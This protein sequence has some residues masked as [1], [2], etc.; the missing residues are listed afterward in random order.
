MKDFTSKMKSVKFH[1][2]FFD[3]QT[4]DYKIEVIECQHDYHKVKKTIRGG[5]IQLRK[6]CLKCGNMEGQPL[7][8]KGVNL[9]TT[10]IAIEIPNTWEDFKNERLLLVDRL[11]K[12]KKAIRQKYYDSPEWKV[13]HKLVLQRDDHKCQACQDKPA[14]QAHHLTYKHWKNEPLFDLVAVCVECH[15]S[16]HKTEKG[17]PFTPIK[18][19]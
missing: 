2:V 9:Q 13:K 3:E 18:H 11:E 6:Q 16:I 5:S 17:E 1:R 19:A 12:A 7:P 4:G 10:P 8:Q 15:E 14:V